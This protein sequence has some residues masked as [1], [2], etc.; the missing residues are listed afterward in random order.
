MSIK[1][2]FSISEL[3]QLAEDPYYFVSSNKKELRELINNLCSLVNP[4]N[5]IQTKDL[6]KIPQSRQNNRVHSEVIIPGK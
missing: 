2:L 5:Q 6:N 4:N 1:D 3:K